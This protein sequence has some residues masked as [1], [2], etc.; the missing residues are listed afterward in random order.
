MRIETR[1]NIFDEKADAVCVTTNGVVCSTG[2]VMGK[3]IAKEADDRYHLKAALGKQLQLYGNHVFDMGVYDGKH[4]V[5][6]PTKNHWHYGSEIH[7]IEQSCRELVTLTNNNDWKE[8]LLTP[9]GCGCGGL[10]FEKDVK[11]VIS[12]ILDER[13]VICFLKTNPQVK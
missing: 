9:V 4:V 5:T 2:A 1:G 3:G 8:V 13:F 11:P 10:D 7:L 12:S 6:F